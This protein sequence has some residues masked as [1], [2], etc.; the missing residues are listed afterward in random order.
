MWVLLETTAPELAEWAG[1]FAA[2]SETHAAAQAGRTS[3][4][5]AADAEELARQAR[6][7]LLLVRESVERKRA[8]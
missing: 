8:A 5:A 7:F 3:R 1:Y 2:H 4:V 6:L